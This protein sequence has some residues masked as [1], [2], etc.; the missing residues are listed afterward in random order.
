[1]LLQSLWPFHTFSLPFDT[2][3][4]LFAFTQIKKSL[5]SFLSPLVMQ[6][7]LPTRLAQGQ[8]LWDRSAR[9]TDYRIFQVG[10][11]PQGSSN[12]TPGSRLDHL[13]FKPYVWEHCLN[14]SW[15][16]AP[17]CHDHHFFQGSTTSVLFLKHNLTLPWHSRTLFL[18]ALQQTFNI[19]G[20]IRAAAAEI[21]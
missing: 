17:W 14:T 20:V 12:P 16:L 19:F 9:I 5:S 13:K 1:M 10:R 21:I 15:A 4:S 6:K 8:A 11:D 2:C 3:Q 18:Q 7:P